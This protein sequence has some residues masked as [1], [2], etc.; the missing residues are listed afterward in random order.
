PER[1]F[2]RGEHPL[3]R[4]RCVPRDAAPHSRHVPALDLAEADTD[5]IAEEAVARVLPEPLGRVE[6]LAALLGETVERVLK[7]AVEL[8]VVRCAE[9]LGLP[10]HGLVL[11]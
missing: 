8:R 11:A 10:V 2:E 6:E 7:A 1:R 9:P 4:E 5:A 3:P